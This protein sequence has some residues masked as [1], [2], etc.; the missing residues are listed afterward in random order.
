M[1]MSSHHLHCCLCGLNHYYL[2][3]VCCKHLFAVVWPST[4]AFYKSI[5][6]TT[7]RSILLKYK[8]KML[9]LYSKSSGIS[10]R[11]RAN[12]LRAFMEWESNSWLG[13]SS[14]PKIHP[15]SP[16]ITTQSWSH[17]S[18]SELPHFSHT[19]LFILLKRGQAY[20]CVRTISITNPFVWDP[21]SSPQ[22]AS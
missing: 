19:N 14:P 5:F 11:M 8:S 15:L 13:P 7:S 6:N 16:S 3:R 2:Y 18:L 4:C 12:F 9:L 22:M 1:V 17:S 20:S 10:H 21:H